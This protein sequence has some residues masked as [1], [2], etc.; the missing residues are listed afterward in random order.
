[1]EYQTGRRD[2]ERSEEST[3]EEGPIITEDSGWQA[4]EYGKSLNICKQV[5]DIVF[6]FIHLLKNTNVAL[7]LCQTLF[8]VLYKYELT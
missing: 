8:Y 6:I 7:T 3:P 5:T 2:R 1:M 4:K